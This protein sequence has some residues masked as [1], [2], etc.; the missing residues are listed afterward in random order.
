MVGE[1]KAWGRRASMILAPLCFLPMLLGAQ[2]A[3]PSTFEGVWCGVADQ[4]PDAGL[5]VTVRLETSGVADSLRVALSL[6]E[7]RLVDLA[8]P[9]PYSDS[10][11]ASIEDGLLML[12]FPPDIGLAFIGNLGIPREAEHI[13]F[14]GTFERGMDGQELRGRIGITTYESPI[15]LSSKRC[16]SPFREQSVA[17]PSAA[18]SLRLAGKL[19]LPDGPGPYPA[20]VFVTGS[21]PDT[22]E[23]WQFEAGALAARGIASLLYDKRGVGESIG[24][25]HDLASW[26]DLAGDVAGAV[27][28]LRSRADLID[29]R[30]IG[31]IGQSQGT[32][33]I[34]KV[35]ADDPQIRFL[36]NISGGGI[37]AA[38]QETYRTGALMR[39]DGFPDGDIE[40]ATAFQRA[41]FAVART[42]VGWEQLDATMQGFRADSVRWFP[43]YGTGAAAQSLAVLRLYGVLQFNYDPTR[44]LERIQSPVFIL[45]G[46]RDVVFPPTVVIERTRAALARGGNE[47]VTSVV[48]PGEGHGHTVVQTSGGR[49]FRRIISEEF[50]RTLTEWVVRQVEN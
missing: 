45:M 14:T 2:S 50:V 36:V 21:D 10:A 6:P 35:A 11:S 49:P 15:V 22:R 33:I 37:S 7:S 12:D 44:D 38:E 28:Y 19:V 18:D 24:A 27:R 16:A 32:W 3:A 23:A 34:T 30:R 8:I 48:I 46:E 5:P 41:K 31:L 39:V 1:I 13:R 43:G 42:G 9:S 17:F 47:A 26:D 20:A 40:R 25:S 29:P 4:K